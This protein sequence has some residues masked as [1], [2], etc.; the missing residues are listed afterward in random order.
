MSIDQCILLFIC[1]IYQV[2]LTTSFNFHSIKSNRYIIAPTNQFIKYIPQKSPTNVALLSSINIINGQSTRPNTITIFP[3]LSNR[4]QRIKN[5]SLQKEILRDITASE[6]ALKI[7]SKRKEVSIDYEK[8]INKLDSNLDLLKSR[9]LLVGSNVSNSINK[10]DKD[11]ASSTGGLIDNDDLFMRIISIKNQLLVAAAQN[12]S[13][14]NAVQMNYNI[15]TN[16]INTNTNSNSNINGITNAA[17]ATVK[18]IRERLR[19]IVREDGTVDWDG[20]IASGREVA[21][22]GT[23]LWE[24]L[25]GKEKAEGLPTITELFGLMQA[26]QP[27]N[28][29]TVRLTEIVK[30]TKDNMAIIQNERDLL[31]NSLRQTRRTGVE[32][33]TNDVQSLRELDLK[34]KEFEKKLKL[35]TL[36]LDMEKICLY[37]QQELEA[38]FEP[39]DQRLFVAEV[40]L[41]DKQ[42]GAMLSGLPIESYSTEDQV[43]SNE[44][45]NSEL[46]RVANLFSLIDDD[47][48]NLI[49]NEV[50]DLKTRLGI[51]TQ[52]FSKTVDWGS[53]GKIASD[54]LAKIKTGLTYFS[55]GTA[56]LF[57]DIAYAL[58]LLAKA[59]G[60]TTLKPREVNAVRRTGKDLITI[61][62]F[63]IILI[64]PLSPVGHVFV[65]GLIQRLWPDFFPSCYS[66]KRL[67]LKKLFAEVERKKYDDILGED[68]FTNGGLLQDWSITDSVRN[69]VEE[70]NTTVT[71]WFSN[72]SN[73][74]TNNPTSDD[75]DKSNKY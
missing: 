65:F 39:S 42:I 32:I 40:T 26:K 1:L 54:S 66:E 69:I 51:D 34:L 20:A 36:N 28:D 52:Q 48:L 74:G 71:G 10:S 8:L 4:V 6:F 63:T 35:F 5:I 41:I 62:P 24:R 50:I 13:S 23:E 57:A 75:I 61:I 60:G 33:S 14:N 17:G 19:V 56:I 53:F 29:E 37:I 58:R 73:T 16:S 44:V 72:T 3:L 38:S 18:E 2:N 59:V 7:E 55:D 12:V 11:D 9:G 30:R 22:F 64:I 46:D 45:N 68:S 21:K 67:N 43:Y 31:R 27:E 70:F 47:E 25:N 15:E 49:Y